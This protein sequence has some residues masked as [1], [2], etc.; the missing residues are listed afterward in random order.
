MTNANLLHQSMQVSEHGISSLAL[1][2]CCNSGRKSANNFEQRTQYLESIGISPVLIARIFE[3]KD[4]IRWLEYRNG[5]QISKDHKLDAIEKY[6]VQDHLTKMT[7]LKLA[8]II[9]LR[10]L[11]R[12]IAENAESIEK[13]KDIK[14]ILERT[15]KWRKKKHKVYPWPEV[16]VRIA[17]EQFSTIVLG[18]NIDKLIKELLKTPNR[19]VVQ[20]LATPTLYDKLVEAILRADHLVLYK[21][22]LNED[23]N[24]NIGY[25]YQYQAIT[26]LKYLLEGEFL[27]QDFVGWAVYFAGGK[28]LQKLIDCD[29]LILGMGYTCTCT[30]ANDR[31]IFKYQPK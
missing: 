24:T 9:Y 26:I 21:M 10:Y 6:D 8:R 29:N 3:N 19:Y 25:V 12:D 28:E 15:D 31:F 4:Y 7:N 2:Q 1:D 23:D 16:I 30:E 11:Y 13:E 5:I 27:H 18:A 20:A 14:K 17:N 22:L